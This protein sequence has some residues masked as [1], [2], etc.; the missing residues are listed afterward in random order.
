MENNSKRER[1]E[2]VASTRVQ[3]VIDMLN[4]LQ[5]CANKGNYEYTDEDVQKM[6]E[7]INKALKNAKSAFASAKDKEGA[8]KFKF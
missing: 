8:R 6:F 5:N 3:K 2:K 1:F 7:A 4:L